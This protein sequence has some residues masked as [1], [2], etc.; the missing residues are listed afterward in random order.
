MCTGTTF[1][2]FCSEKRWKAVVYYEI[3]RRE[4]IAKRIP[5][6]LRCQILVWRCRCWEASRSAKVASQN[7]PCPP[8]HQVAAVLRRWWR[9]NDKVVSMVITLNNHFLIQTIMH[10]LFFCLALLHQP[11]WSP[12][13]PSFLFQRKLLDFVVLRLTDFVFLLL[14]SCVLQKHKTCRPQ[15][16]K[17]KQFEKERRREGR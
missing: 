16:N 12:L 17:I 5:N 9:F 3:A 8:L 4:D 10:S 7:T 13:S 14:L 11:F 1:S 15:N 6:S 2:W